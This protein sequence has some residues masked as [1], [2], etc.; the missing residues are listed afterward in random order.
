MDNNKTMR[1]NFK[2]VSTLRVLAIGGVILTIFG[3][4]LIFFFGGFLAANRIGQN[5]SLAQQYNSIIA[6]S[7]NSG[8]FNGTSGLFN[9][10]NSTVNSYK[11]TGFLTAV[12]NTLN[13]AANFAVKI[14]PI[15]NALISFAASPFIALGFPLT[16]AIDA[17]YALIIIAVALAILTI[18]SLVY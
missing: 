13:T 17:A 8:I 16:Y 5:S 14:V 10:T 15:W 18:W 12:L 6:N 4:M 1:K 11:S 7:L 3:F 2:G 9:N